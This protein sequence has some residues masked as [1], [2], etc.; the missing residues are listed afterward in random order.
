MEPDDLRDGGDQYSSFEP[1]VIIAGKPNQTFTVRMKLQSTGQTQPGEVSVYFYVSADASIT[2]S[3]YYLGQTG[4][5]LGGGADAMLILRCTFPT[6][7]PQGSYY[8]G[9][10]IDPEKRV[11]E[12]NET[13][14]TAYKSTPRLNVVSESQSPVYV[15]ATAKGTNS[16][17][18]WKN[19]FTSLQDALA[20]AIP[21][22]EIRVA[23]GV[24]TPDQGI[25][26]VRGNREAS[27]ALR[28][29]ITILGG[30]AGAGAADPNARDIKA[31]ATVLS[32]DLKAND[33]PV[34]DPCNFWK[35]SSRTD[36]SRHVLTALN[37]DRTTT[38]DG[39]QV[40]GGYAYGPSATTAFTDDLQGAGLTMSAGSLSLRNCTFTGNWASGDG[41]AI[42]ADGGTLG[43]A[44]CTFRANG[45]GARALPSKTSGPAD[46]ARGT[47]GAI[48]TDGRGQTTLARCKFY[49]NFAGAQGGAFDNNKGNATLTQCLFIQNNAGS[50]GGGALWNSEGQLNMVNCTLNGNRSDY[51]GGAIANG[52]SGT[53]NAANCCLHANYAKVQA[54]AIDN[55]FGGKATLWNCT[56]AANRQDGNLGAIVCGPAL[57]QAGSELTVANCILWDGGNEISNQG[58]SL[59]TV[60][61][62]DI[63]G[64]WAGA[65]NI[66]AGPLFLLAVGLDSIA[67]T[68]D[69]N[70]RLAEGSPCID[71]GDNALLPQDFADLDGDGNL[72]EALP[73]D[74]DN[75][76]RLSGTVDMGAYERD[77]SAPASVPCSGG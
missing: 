32:G 34:V 52:W 44:D 36:N 61:R 47:G 5:W 69:D 68:E 57:G 24:Y 70:L 73:L 35:E 49:G 15:D 38:L 16:G 28:S 45:A 54:G 23:D 33:L 55:F 1:T 71:H 46:P 6:S 72:K 4:A 19:A 42:Y 13:N 3:D 11:A 30:Y 64:G 56:L 2:S 17:S 60:G 26:I 59:I 18:S 39:V 27:F 40:T 37:L 63:Q 10:I 76:A 58:K 9:W 77:P 22:R 74:L 43:L 48:R 21:G 51:S 8:V 65:T 20:V 75:R 14:N 62:T 41:G 53:L 50:A 67:G 66:N 31:Y 12:A 7:I 25:E 29:G